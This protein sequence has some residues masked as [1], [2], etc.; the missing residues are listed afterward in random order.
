MKTALVGCTGFVG[1]NLAARHP[2][3]GLYHASNVADAFG[4]RPELLVYAGLPAAKYLANADPAADLAVCGAAAENMRRIAPERLVF[5]ST[6]DVYARPQNVWEDTFPDADNPAAY[7]RNRA[8]L[9]ARVRADFPQALIVRLPGLFGQGLKKNFLYDFI[10]VTPSMLNAEMFARLAGESLVKSAYAP[11]QNGFWA[12][13]PD[14]SAAETAQLRAFF[15]QNGWNALSFT[16]SRS[17]YQFYDLARLWQD[18]SVALAAHLRLLN[19]ATEP[20]GTA[21]VY[22]ALTHGGVFANEL[23]GAPARYDMRSRCDALFGG[24]NGYLYEKQQV[25]DDVCAFVR[26]ALQQAPC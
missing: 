3:D 7:G 25:L 18:I 9:E 14:L 2:F 8:L 12:L 15:A 22:A 20:V 26:R 19:V 24:H 6:V 5:I 10:R 23:P 1:G 21:E 16:D 13:R 17:T 4:T 11:A